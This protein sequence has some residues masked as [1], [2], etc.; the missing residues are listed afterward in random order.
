MSD[1]K[2]ASRF[3]EIYNSTNK[4][5]LTYIPLED[6]ELMPE[7][8]FVIDGADEHGVVYEY[9]AAPDYAA[10]MIVL[11]HE[12]K[13]DENGIYRSGWMVIG[14]EALM[15]VVKRNENGVMT[16]MVYRVP[17]EIVRSIYPR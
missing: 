3:G 9:D 10:P 2:A 12:L 1:P 5:V 17:E 8:V 4:A 6:C 11:E 7:S 13:F 15:S 16:G 14:S